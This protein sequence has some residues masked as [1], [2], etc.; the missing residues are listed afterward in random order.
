MRKILKYVACTVAALVAVTLGG[1]AA[2]PPVKTGQLPSNVRVAQDPLISLDWATVF[3]R[4][5]KVV[6][7]EGGVD[8]V[9]LRDRISDGVGVDSSVLVAGDSRT[10]DN[11]V[12]ARAHDLGN[13]Y[14]LAR[15]DRGG[16]LQIYA[17]VERLD[18]S[19]DTFVE[20]EFN[21]GVV[22]VQQGAPWPIHGERLPGDLLARVDF[23]TGVFTGA[24]L[25]RW[26]GTAYEVLA[27]TG[28][29]GNGGPDFFVCVGAPPL[30]PVAAEVWD[31][32]G[33]PAQVLEPR[34]FLEIG[35]NVATLLGASPEFTSIQVRTP[36]DIILDSFR[37][38]GLWAHRRAGG[39]EQ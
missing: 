3:G 24:T 34:S 26:D 23:T 7:L 38:I 9:F 20:F 14:V 39:G 21:Q 11:G 6:D 25:M 1:Q 36:E 32:T 28:P 29:A 30:A 31:E 10:V 13:G 8:A 27:S 18:S 19:D 37:R 15:R 33:E 4:D 35:V 5:G 12:V 17:G 22:E 2:A 16:S